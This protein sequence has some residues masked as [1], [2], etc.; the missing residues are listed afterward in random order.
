MEIKLFVFLVEF[1]QVFKF[2]ENVAKHDKKNFESFS[3]SLEVK[4][5]RTRLAYCHACSIFAQFCMC[6]LV[7]RQS[8]LPNMQKL[9]N[10]EQDNKNQSESVQMTTW[11][12]NDIFRTLPNIFGRSFCSK[13]NWLLVVIYF[14]KMFC[15]RRLI[16]F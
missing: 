12:K 16:W 8:F 9:T 15:Q 11:A 4:S 13:A 14:C 7:V 2:H 6:S 3:M 5:H 10:Q 1:F